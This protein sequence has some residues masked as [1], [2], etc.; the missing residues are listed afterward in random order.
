MYSILPVVRQDIM[1]NF[2]CGMARDADKF[3][4]QWRIK[5]LAALNR[6]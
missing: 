1:G 5:F 2:M 4:A 3:P 6:H